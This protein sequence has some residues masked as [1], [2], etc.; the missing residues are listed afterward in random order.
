MPGYSADA[1]AGTVIAQSI[2]PGEVVAE[3]TELILTV[4]QP[5]QMLYYPPSN[6]TLVRA[7]GRCGGGV[8]EITPPSGATFMGFSGMLDAGT[9]SIELSSVEQ[10]LH[11]VREYMDGV[12]M[13]ET[14]VMFE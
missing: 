12:L 10:G 1:P 9:Y 13:V 3:G 6:Y 4:S 8:L 5:R 14:Q 2:P 11:T 7:S